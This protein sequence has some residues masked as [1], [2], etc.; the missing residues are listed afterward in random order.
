MAI[1]KQRLFFCTSDHALTCTGGKTCGA[2]DNPAAD[3]RGGND[4]G[5]RGEPLAEV[6]PVPKEARRIP[7]G[8]SAS[9][10]HPPAGPAGTLPYPSPPVSITKPT[11]NHQAFH[12]PI[13]C[14][15]ISIYIL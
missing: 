1:W 13:C 2:K 15:V 3:E 10:G 6:P 9:P 5:E 8:R 11:V 12:F 14:A 7:F 4:A